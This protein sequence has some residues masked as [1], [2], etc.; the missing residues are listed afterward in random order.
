MWVIRHRKMACRGHRGDGGHEERQD[1]VPPVPTA[2]PGQRAIRTAEELCGNGSA[3][4]GQESA[5]GFFYALPARTPPFIKAG[6]RLRGEALSRQQSITRSRART[7][8]RIS[9]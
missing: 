9:G 8:F 6:A 4:G 7:V 3:V 1:A 5:R 2:L